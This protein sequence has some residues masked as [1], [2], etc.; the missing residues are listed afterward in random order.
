MFYQKRRDNHSY[1]IVH[2]ARPPK[3]PESGVDDG[4]AGHSLLPC[5][6]LGCVSIPGKVGKF[7]PEGFVRSLRK[8]AEQMVSELAPANLPQENH[9]ATMRR[10]NSTGFR[11]GL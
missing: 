6:E 9:P 10:K 1:T 4:I 11:E 8:M 2:P 5:R 3:L 7:R